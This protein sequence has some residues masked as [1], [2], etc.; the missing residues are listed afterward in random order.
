MRSFFS[1]KGA[2][3]GNAST[4]AGFVV[5]L[6]ATLGLAFFFTAFP[7][8][9]YPCVSRCRIV[10]ARSL[11]SVGLFFLEWRKRQRVVARSA[12]R[13]E[14]IGPQAVVDFL[15]NIRACLAAMSFGRT[16]DHWSNPVREANLQKFLIHGE[17]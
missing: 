16:G 9:K 17:T 1:G 11:W 4:D 15:P 14:P 2:A 8:C 6:F 13:I 3:C 12:R 10:N 7:T 5:A